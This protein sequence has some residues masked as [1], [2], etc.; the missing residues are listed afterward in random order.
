MMAG[1]RR[2]ALANRIPGPRSPSS[3][4]SYTNCA[5]VTIRTFEPLSSHLANV[6]GCPIARECCPCNHVTVKPTH[7]P[8][9]PS[10]HSPA[11]GRYGTMGNFP[12]L[13]AVGIFCS[14]CHGTS[15]HVLFLVTDSC[16]DLS[17]VRYYIAPCDA[18]VTLVTRRAYLAEWRRTV[19]RASLSWPRSCW[20]RKLQVERSRA[21]VDASTRRRRGLPKHMRICL[22]QPR[23]VTATSGST[24]T[25][26]G[27]RVKHPSV[28]LNSRDARAGQ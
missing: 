7:P 10:C 21:R 9:P 11:R 1:A 26:F 24:I 20:W 22:S 18:S 4:R 13:M 27:D 28:S 3:R 8:H 14:N 17:A 19:K 6:R 15:I 16:L 12:R 25:V 23:F 5:Y 2:A